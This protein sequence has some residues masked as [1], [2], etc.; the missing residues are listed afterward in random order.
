M[1]DDSDPEDDFPLGWDE[2]WRDPHDDPEPIGCCDECECNL[3]GGEIDD[4]VLCDRCAW[5]ASVRAAIWRDVGREK[6][7]LP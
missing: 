3:Y 7:K 4:G 1:L 6:G 2:D 5:S